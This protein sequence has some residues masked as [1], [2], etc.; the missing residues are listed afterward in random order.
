MFDESII[1]PFCY[2]FMKD[3]QK[4]Y[5]GNSLTEKGFGESTNKI[6]FPHSHSRNFSWCLH[7]YHIWILRIS[8]GP[9]VLVHLSVQLKSCL[10]GPQNGIIKIFVTFMSLY[11][12]LRILNTVPFWYMF[13]RDWSKIGLCGDLKPDNF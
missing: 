10:I 3:F 8:V 13:I 9:V 7:Y 4:V 11:T 5:Q 12:I 6:S 2:Y 1:L